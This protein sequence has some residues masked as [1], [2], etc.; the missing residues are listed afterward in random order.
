[1]PTLFREFWPLAWSPNQNEINGDPKGLLRN[2][3]LN[4]DETGVLG[5]I[6]GTKKISHAPLASE[7][8][9]I[10]GKLLDLN[11]I[12][13]STGGYPSAPNHVRYAVLNNGQTVVRNYGGNKSETIYDLGLISGGGNQGVGFGFGFGHVFITSGAE[14]WKDDGITQTRL[15]MNGPA[16]PGAGY[17]VSPSVSMRGPYPTFYEWAENESGDYPDGTGLYFVNSG[18]YVEIGTAVDPTTNSFRAITTAGEFLALNI[19]G[20]AIGGIAGTG[21]ADDSY[22]VDVRI[23][24]TSTLVKVR[25]E[26]LL[27]T[28]IPVSGVYQPPAISDYYFHEWTAESGVF[29]SGID[30]W[31]TLETRRDGFER[32]GTDSGRDWSTIKGIRVIFVATEFQ[33]CALTNPRFIGGAKGPLDGFYNYIAV[34]VVNNNFYLEKSLPSVAS[35]TVQVIHSSAY[36]MPSAVHSQAN[37]CWIFRGSSNY[38]GY[39]RVKVIHGT[40]GFTPAVFNDEMT[41]EQA[42]ALNI[43]LDYYQQ[44]L[45]D[46]IIGIET[47]FKGR[48]WYITYEKVYPSYRDNISS[49][50]SRFVVETS[51]NTEYNLFITKLSTD[52]MVL[53]TN[54]DF[55]EISGSAGIINENN[56]DFFDITVRPLGIKSP[57]INKEFVVHEGNLFYL[58]GDGIRVLSGSKCQLI[59]QPLD[60]LFNHHTRHGVSPVLIKPLDRH[61]IDI[62]NNRLYFSTPQEDNRRALYIYN[63]NHQ[64]WRLE[65]HGD[66]DSISAIFVEED[67]TII[68]STASFG[69]K[70]MRQLDVGTLFDETNNIPFKM[71]TIFDH[72][73]QPRNRKD[74]FTLKVTADTGNTPINVILRGYRDDKNIVTY[75]TTRAFDGRTEQY[76]SV[77]NELSSSV[78]F[79]QLELNGS[80]PKFK[81]FNFSVDYEARPEQLTNL[82]IPP[83]N[84]G[85]AGRKRVPEI[86][87][88]I[89]TLGKHV[90]FT[91]IL[92]GVV[93]TTGTIQTF[94]RN[95]YHYL[96]NADKTAYNV[97]GLLQSPTGDIFEFYELVNPREVELIPDPLLY[98]WVPY[99]NFNT[100]SRKRFIQYGIVIDTRGQDV[101]LLPF[102]D[103]IAQEIKVVN[104]DN[105]RTALTTMPQSAVGIDIACQLQALSQTPFEFYGVSIDD[106]VFEKLPPVSRYLTLQ[107]TNYGCAGKKRIRTIPMVIDTKGGNVTFTPI[108]DGVSYPASSFNTSDKRTVLHYFQ[109]QGTNGVPFG[110]DY[111]G[112]LQSATDFEFYELLKPA[113][114]ETLPVGKMFDQFGPVEFSKVGKIREVSIRMM[115]TGSILNY[116]IFAQD[117]SILAGSITTVPDHEKTYVISVPKGVNPNIFRMEIDSPSVFHRWDVEVKVNIDGAVTEN[118]RLKIPNPTECK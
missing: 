2:D 64:H 53:A 91:P 18:D 117:T 58:A 35:E 22:R 56:I 27:D 52:S 114:V 12:Q 15:G 86:P 29:N 118:R 107:T 110:I 38:T 115:A 113:N 94:D 100:T 57:P 33:K 83:S 5:L 21:R 90:N 48:N 96:F 78:K 45:P 73:G 70:F 39:Y 81:I 32:V 95:V 65:D 92:D 61:Y 84:Y 40:N 60:L 51:G 4:I 8:T 105:K 89:D 14:K 82:R 20:T 28:P 66:T 9:Q 93:Q 101:Q 74:T 11:S 88:I 68:Y 16:P 13:N 3:N 103:G 6:R 111:G 98:K 34:S 109:N 72:N 85:I 59:T 63:F 106:S 71:L 25:I 49:Y 46:G 1:M 41:D 31:T 104:T 26:Y 76:F 30:A 23:G 36:V 116:R 108:V 80:V 19:D 79:Y 44:N 42:L 97:G 77:Y 10:F 87:M 55:Y 24:N 50:D 102:I 7:P 99:T 37:E 43:Q 67:D 47:N 54:N 69:D 62:A 112:I 17:N 75:N